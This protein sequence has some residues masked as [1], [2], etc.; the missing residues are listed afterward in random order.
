MKTNRILQTLDYE[1]A[2]VHDVQAGIPISLE[3]VLLVI[4]GLRTDKEIQSYQTKIDDIFHHFLSKCNK[5]GL[6]T[7]TEAPLYLHRRIAQCLFEYLWNS[8][9]KRF[10]EHFL[11]TDVIDA[12]LSPDL[13]HPVGT[14]IG[15]TCLFSVL[16]LRAGLNLSVLMDSE[17]LLSR[18]NLGDHTIDIDHTDPQGFDCRNCEDFFEFSL[19]ALAANVLNSRGM[20][21][22]RSGQLAAAKKDYQKAVRVNPDYANAYNN[23]GNMIFLDEDMEGAIADYDAAIRLNSSFCEAYCNRGMA[24]QRLGRHDEARLDYN[25]AISLNSAYTDARTCVQLL[26]DA[27]RDTQCFRQ[28]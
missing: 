22:E 15:L 5:D 21:N 13:H 3:R 28:G 27:E 14:C 19:P 23:R 20:Q 11:L 4:S 17:H 7:R 24:K 10:G 9:P 26:D 8:K 1:E 12:Q 25:T 6:L 18:L 16:G 2:I